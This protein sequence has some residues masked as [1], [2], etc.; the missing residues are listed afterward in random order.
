MAFGGLCASQEMQE[1]K[2]GYV[3]CSGKKFRVATQVTMMS[4]KP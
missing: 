1:Q 4:A 2:Y 3:V